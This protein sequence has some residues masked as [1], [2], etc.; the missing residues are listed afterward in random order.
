VTHPR[1]C[2]KAQKRIL[3]WWSPHDARRQINNTRLDQNQKV[4]EQ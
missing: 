2:H 1:V 3:P 4:N